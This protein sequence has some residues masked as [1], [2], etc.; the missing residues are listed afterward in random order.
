MAK[1]NNNSRR[2]QRNLN[3]KRQFASRIG[4]Y[5][6]AVG[7]GA[8][9]FGEAANAA[10]IYV[11]IPDQIVTEG[12]DFS[13]NM[14][15]AGYSDFKVQNFNFGASYTRFRLRGQ[16]STL[17]LTNLAKGSAYYVRSFEAGNVIGNNA[18]T[19]VTS[20][21]GHVAKQDATNFGNLTNPQFAG[22]KLKDA[23]GDLH[24]GWV[25]ISWDNTLKQAT[26]YDYAYESDLSSQSNIVAG[27]IPEPTSLA[28]LAAGVGALG[29]RRRTR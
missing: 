18:T 10:I 13:I 3:N 8:F 23:G 19:G 24:W 28:L 12:N 11:D 5:T 15:G 20:G 21:S 16:Y 4:S 27:A 7:L 25:R 29:L 14:D 9:G 26:I 2:P 22:V 1:K 6:A 17:D